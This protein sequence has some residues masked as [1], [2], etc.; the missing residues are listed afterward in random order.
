MAT[1]VIELESF[2]TSAGLR[3]A[4]PDRPLGVIRVE[5]A[6]VRSLLDEVDR[7]PVAS[8]SSSA[9]GQLAEELTRLGCRLLETASSLRARDLRDSSVD[10]AEPEIRRGWEGWGPDG[11]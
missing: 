7:L 9:Q 6:V 11:G 5:L 2:P 8:S 1:Q 10:G 3:A 4:R